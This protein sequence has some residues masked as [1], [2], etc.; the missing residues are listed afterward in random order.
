MRAF[1]LSLTVFIAINS[2]GQIDGLWVVKK[3]MVGAE[4]LTPVSKWMKLEQGKQLSGNGWQQHSFGTY[5]W[6]KKTSLLSFQTTNEPADEFEPFKV[7][8]TNSGMTWTRMEE[9][10][11]VAVDLERTVDLPMSPADQIKGLWELESAQK[12]DQDITTVYDPAGDHFMFIRW[13]RIYVR[14]IHHDQQIRGYWFMNGHRPELRLISESEDQP[15]EK[16]MISF[17]EEK[18]VWS[19]LSENV[20]GMRLTYT[21][22]SDFPK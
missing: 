20:Q 18:M 1:I 6:D 12:L 10:V 16:W 14:Q 15:S 11:L 22:L 3:V 13:D 4:D 5:K 19:G 9:G 2:F 8:I 17:E 7:S 21:R